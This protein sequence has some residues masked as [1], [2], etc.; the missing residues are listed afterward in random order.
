MKGDKIPLKVVKIGILG[1]TCVGKLSICKSY[2]GYEFNENSLNNN[3]SHGKFETKFILDNGKEIRLI[4]WSAPGQERFHS[5][6]L[7]TMKSVNGILL[8]AD[9]TRKESFDNIKKWLRDIEDNLNNPYIVLFGNKADLK[10]QWEITSEEAKKYAEENKLIYFETSAKT[11]QGINEGISYI[12][13]Q[14]YKKVK[15]K[16]NKNIYIGKGTRKTT[17][18]KCSPSN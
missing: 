10:D 3:I 18:S 1:D 13:N 12:V 14:A 9:L 5:I 2:L 8:I 4:I 7:N 16:L 6:A 11:K 15:Q 17:K